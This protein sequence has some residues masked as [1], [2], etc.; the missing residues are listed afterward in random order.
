MAPTLAMSVTGVQVVRLLG[1]AAPLAYVLAGIGMALI[2]FGFVRLSAAFSH[3]GS[4]YAFIGKT[5][6]PR[7]GFFASWALIG[8]YIVFPPVSVLGMAAFTQAFLRHTGISSSVDWLPIALVSWALVWIL[9]ARGI[10]LTAASVIAVEAVSL[11][12]IVALITI[13]L[14]RLG[15]GDAPSHQALNLDVVKIPPGTGLATIGLAATF[16]ILSFGGFESAMSAGEESQHPRSVIPRSI[17]AAVAFGGVFYVFCIS[18]QVLGFGS[19]SAG[20][21]QFAHSTAPLGDL[22]HIYVGSAMAD[23]LDVAAVLSS[24]GAALV[25]V[26][27]ASRTLFALARDR[28]L[29][30][31]VAEVSKSTGTP[32]G[33]VAMSML[34]TL[35]LLLAFGI[36]GTSALNA[37]FYLATIGTLSLLVLYV[38]VSVSAMKLE[39]SKGS[40]RRSVVGLVVPIGG[41]AVALYVLYRNLVPAPASPYDVFPYIVLA[42]LVLG[43]T[44][45]VVV[46]SVRERVA[47][48]LSAGDPAPASRPAPVDAEITT[49]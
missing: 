35:A 5:L 17:I 3:A 18:S 44:I 33:A 6:G 39:F 4:V 9:V 10:K 40:G 38:L 2:G 8:T 30:G 41:A 27:V 20:V 31:R 7:A 36:G 24:L 16:G 22:A 25:G 19:D 15:I 46:P 34:M 1:R 13:I 32:T 42:W 29:T 11:V 26:A 23:L 21:A 45:A 14:V 43:A 28:M 37:F 47:L 12:L 48:G 49:S